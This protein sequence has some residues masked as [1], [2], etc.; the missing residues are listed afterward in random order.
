MLIPHVICS[1]RFGYV[2]TLQAFGEHYLFIRY[3]EIG[4]FFFNFYLIFTSHISNWRWSSLVVSF[5]D[6]SPDP[7]AIAHTFI[8]Y[9]FADS[10]A[11]HVLLINLY[12]CASP[13]HNE[14]KTGRI[15]INVGLFGL[16]N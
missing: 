3:E 16:R 2:V 13:K 6:T 14:S 1:A 7:I 4:R 8:F 12:F 5:S 11:V 10:I 15:A 9:I